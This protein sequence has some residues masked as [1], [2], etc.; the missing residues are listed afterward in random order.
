MFCDVK[1]PVYAFI[2]LSFFKQI[3]ELARNPL[4]LNFLCLLL[5][6]VQ[7]CCIM[8]SSTFSTKFAL[9]FQSQLE[10]NHKALHPFHASKLQWKIRLISV[11]LEIVYS[12]VLEKYMEQSQN[13][14]LS[15]EREC[16]AE[17]CLFVK[18]LYFITIYE[19]SINS[20]PI[21]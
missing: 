7:Q 16:T 18:F 5:H 11:N 21:I 20:V 19:F 14:V 10:N 13:T 8:C 12:T 9:H 17:L 15:V 3:M 1:M 6:F 4:L 2:S